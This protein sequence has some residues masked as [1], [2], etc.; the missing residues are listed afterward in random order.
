[1]TAQESMA[2][3]SSHRAGMKRSQHHRQQECDSRKQEI[4]WGSCPVTEAHTREHDQRGG[5]AETVQR[6]AAELQRRRQI[7]ELSRD[8][9]TQHQE[10]WCHARRS[11]RPHT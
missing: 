4:R 10:P 7:E 8:Q 2:A 11:T 9:H 5:C 6:H 1:M 3:R